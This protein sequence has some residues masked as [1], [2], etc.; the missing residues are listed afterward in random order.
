M[1]LRPPFESIYSSL[2]YVRCT[3]VL[4]SRYKNLMLMLF[5]A[6]VPFIYPLTDDRC[7][8]DHKLELVEFFLDFPSTSP[9]LNIAFEALAFSFVF[10]SFL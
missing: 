3:V 5:R 8:E 2:Q 4:C 9:V 6:E 10:Y 7:V 1:F